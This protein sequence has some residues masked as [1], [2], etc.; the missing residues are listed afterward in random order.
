MVFGFGENDKYGKID[1]SKLRDGL[2][3]EDLNILEGSVEAS[4]FDSVDSDKN[5]KLSRT[6]INI[7]NISCLIY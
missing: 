2:T 4:I 1:F 5:K 7:F 6:E 3:K